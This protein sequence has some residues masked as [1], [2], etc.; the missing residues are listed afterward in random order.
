MNTIY[1]SIRMCVVAGLMLLLAC[2]RKDD[3][4]PVDTKVGFYNASEFVRLQLQNNYRP[5][6][7]FIDTKDTVGIATTPRFQTGTFVNQFPNIFYYQNHPQPWLDY[8][9][10]FAGT[11][12]LLLMDTSGHR[13]LVKDS[14]VAR[15]DQQ[16]TI[17]F[18]DSLGKFRTWKVSDE[19]NIATDAIGLRLIHLSPDFGK[20]YFTVNGQK[21]TGFPASVDYGD[22]TAF[23]PRPVKGPDTLKIRIYHPETPEQSVLSATLLTTPG[24]AYNIVLK[25]YENAQSFNDPV[26]GDFLSFDGSLRVALTQ[27]K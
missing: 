1:T 18:A 23:I 12:Q 10:L 5:G 13:V 25:G 24:S 14:L 27:V 2:S 21:V 19:A 22:V 11:H 15:H 3:L 9:H 20:M 8:M 4:S 17:Y 16:T 26:T 6:Y 7:L